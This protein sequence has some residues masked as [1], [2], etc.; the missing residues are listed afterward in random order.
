[1]SLLR[2]RVS[3][4]AQIATNRRNARQSTGPRSARGKAQPRL[5]RLRDGSRSRLYQ[6][7]MWKLMNAPHGAGRP[8]PR[9]GRAP[10]V[11]GIDADFLPGESAS[12]SHPARLR[13][14]AGLAKRLFFI[15]TK[16]LSL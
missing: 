1:M 4:P 13:R 5:N 12:G 8:R 6:D 2:P 9:T 10:L 3:S 7:L 14:G 11:C 15:R 16:P